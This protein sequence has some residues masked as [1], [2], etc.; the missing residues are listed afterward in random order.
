[1]TTAEHRR[2]ID[3]LDAEIVRLLNERTAHVLEIGENKLKT[4]KELY[5]PDRIKKLIA[6]LRRQ[7]KGPLSDE[8]LRAIYRE[9]ISSSLA[10]QKSMTIAYLGGLRV[11]VDAADGTRVH[12][13]FV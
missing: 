5:T 6:R 10:L 4:G 1:M 7:N 13:R 3:K 8:S 11:D 2:A 12:F 9:I